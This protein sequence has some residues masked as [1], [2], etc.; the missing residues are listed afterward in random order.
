MLRF[1]QD[2]A[3]V[4]DAVVKNMASPD[5]RTFPLEG[6]GRRAGFSSLIYQD[7][8]LMNKGEF[9]KTFQTA[10]KVKDPKCPQ[11]LV[12]NAQKETESC[13]VFKDPACPF[14]RLRLAAMTEDYNDIEF[15]EK[16]GCFHAE[17]GSRTVALTLKDRL[18]KS[19]AAELLG[20]QVCLST[21]PEYFY[22]LHK[23]PMESAE[24]ASS[25]GVPAPGE[26]APAAEE[27]VL[28]QTKAVVD[29]E[30]PAAQSENA[31]VLSA[32]VRCLLT[33]TPV[34]DEKS[35]KRKES[36]PSS[37][38]D[39]KRMHRQ[40]SSMSIGGLDSKAS[41]QG[42][43]EGG[44]EEDEEVASRLSALSAPQQGS[45]KATEP[46]TAGKWI[47]TLEP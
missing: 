24:A 25:A 11:V 19:H 37:S 8:I 28:D 6:V 15:L 47:T 41:D 27:S 16:A 21:V 23:R 29:E 22:K 5:L 34:A 14:R 45:G 1:C 39:S 13:F 26:A 33:S 10:P 7:Y 43:D 18:E 9:Q 3:K 40:G 4:R 38:G 36:M 35:K 20:K 44:A 2:G 12:T 17:Q 46:E 32:P 42:G 31:E 30:F